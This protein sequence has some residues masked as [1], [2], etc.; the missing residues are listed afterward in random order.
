MIHKQN[1][2]SVVTDNTTSANILNDDCQQ[3]RPKSID[4]RFYWIHDRI[5]QDQFH[6]S[7]APA[8]TNLGDYPS[9]NHSP[10]H[11]KRMRPFFVHTDTYPDTIPIDMRGC[12]DSHVKTLRKNN[13][14]NHI[15]QDDATS[16]HRDLAKIQYISKIRTPYRRSPH[17]QDQQSQPL[18]RTAVA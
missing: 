14:R 1:P 3:R 16:V 9:K 13:I 2:T 18:R 10:I 12:V 8:H 6:I 11:H 7:W 5:K 4:M 17:I 15:T